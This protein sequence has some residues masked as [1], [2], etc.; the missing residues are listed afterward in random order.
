MTTIMWVALAVVSAHQAWKFRHVLKLTFASAS[1][2]LWPND[3]TGWQLELILW[4]KIVVLATIA[5]MAVGWL[6]S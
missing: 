6:I 2:K 4:A 1:W 3:R 5:G